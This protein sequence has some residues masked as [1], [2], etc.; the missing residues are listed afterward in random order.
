MLILLCNRN[1]Q[2]IIHEKLFQISFL[3]L[4]LYMKLFTILI[5]FLYFHTATSQSNWTAAKF[6]IKWIIWLICIFFLS[7]WWD[8]WCL[9]DLC[10]NLLF[11]IL[12]QQNRNNMLSHVLQFL[13][14]NHINKQKNLFWILIFC[15]RMLWNQFCLF[16]FK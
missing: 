14:F 5:F 10:M 12:S 7:C 8:F 4:N 6:V 13:L 11:D 1:Q 15:L 16:L 3:F 9:L 2:K